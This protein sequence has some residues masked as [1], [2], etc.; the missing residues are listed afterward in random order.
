M[1]TVGVIM[2]YMFTVKEAYLVVT[3][4]VFS[5]FLPLILSFEETRF[6]VVDADRSCMMGP[7]LQGC[8][9]IQNQEVFSYRIQPTSRLR[10]SSLKMIRFKTSSFAEMLQRIM[11]IK[12]LSC[13]S[14]RF[15]FCFG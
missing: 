8:F 11:R 6:S 5:A 3:S 1:A 7:I 4:P 2:A 12:H 9:R 10:G 15:W 14:S 13:Y